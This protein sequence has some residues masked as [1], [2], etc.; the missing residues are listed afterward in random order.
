MIHYPEDRRIWAHDIRRPLGEF[1]R[2]WDPARIARAGFVLG[3]PRLVAVALEMNDYRRVSDATATEA[4]SG[5][6]LQVH[7]APTLVDLLRDGEL[8][9]H[10]VARFGTALDEQNFR[11]WLFR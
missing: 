8:K 6:A 7:L 11:D 9:T 1:E 4:T 5:V 2:L 3:V 10:L